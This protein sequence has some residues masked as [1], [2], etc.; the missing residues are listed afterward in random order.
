MYK[1]NQINYKKKKIKRVYLTVCFYK[2]KKNTHDTPT[3][4]MAIEKE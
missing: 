4:Y 2:L 1:A 3:E